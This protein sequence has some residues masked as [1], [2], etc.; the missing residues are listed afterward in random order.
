MNKQ[1]TLKATLLAVAL[2]LGLV[3]APALAQQDLDEGGFTPA[4][5]D[6]ALFTYLE[7]EVDYTGQDGGQL[8]WDAESWI[9]G[10]DQRLWLR[11]DGER[12]DGE[13]EEAQLQVLY[14]RSLSAFWDWRVGLRH[15]FEP[16]SL[17]YAVL[18]I[19]GLAPY[20]F[21]TDASLYLSEDGDL[22]LGF[23]T[24]Y[25]LLITQRLVAQPYLDL[26]LYAQDVPELGK[27]AG[28][29]E[30]TAGLRVRYEI[31]REFA[32]YIDVSYTRLPGETGRIARAAGEDTEELA[33]RAGLRVW[34]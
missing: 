14:G 1:N 18:G 9:G 20:R 34:F 16:R 23:E 8:R 26:E 24:E 22:S 29:T 15:D 33:L 11:T 6:D 10:D 21:E 13:V 25:D 2:P 28:L 5:T 32:P 3:G 31:R 30:A 4:F 17:N 19:E 12:H 27:G 7:A